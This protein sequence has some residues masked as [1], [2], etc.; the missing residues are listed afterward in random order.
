MINWLKA[1]CPVCHRVY[2]YP[3]GGYCPKTCADFDCVQKFAHHPERY[4]D[5]NELIDDC[6]RKAGV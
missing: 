6:R 3:E 1:R 2:E 5:I 4:R